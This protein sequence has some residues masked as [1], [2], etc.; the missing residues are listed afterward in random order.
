MSNVFNLDGTPLFIGN[1]DEIKKMLVRQGET[2]R[3]P[4]GW[5]TFDDASNGGFIYGQ[6]T[7][8]CGAPNAG[9]TAMLACLTDYWSQRGIPV[10]A[11][12][13]D[14]SPDEFYMRWGTMLGY[15]MEECDKRSLEIL[16]HIADHLKG[17][18]IYLLDRLHTIEQAVDKFITMF[19]PPI[20]LVMISDSLQRIRCDAIT[21]KDADKDKVAKN[22]NALEKASKS[23]KWATVTTSEMSR[24]GYLEKEEFNDM[25]AGKHNGDIEYVAKA[26][27]VVRCDKNDDTV[28]KVTVPKLKRGKKDHTEFYLRFDRSMHT[29]T[30]IDQPNVQTDYSRIKN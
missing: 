8:I 12:L 6:C 22:L 30:E 17:R 23:Y 28:R 29:L 19:P 26:Q 27:L 9:K 15:T 10:C 11:L 24:S 13:V 21:S 20:Q 2:M 18:P 4:T 3:V 5:R 25:S 7:F 1:I 16:Y 14:E